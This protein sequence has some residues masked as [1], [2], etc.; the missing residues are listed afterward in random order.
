[1]TTGLMPVRMAVEM[2]CPGS[3]DTTMF[4]FPQKFAKSFSTNFSQMSNRAPR[5]GAASAPT[6]PIARP[7]SSPSQQADVTG[8]ITDALPK[9]AHDEGIAAVLE[10]RLAPSLHRSD[11][12]FWCPHRP[13]A[14]HYISLT[15]HVTWKLPSP[16]NAMTR[17]L[18]RTATA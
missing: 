9:E 13:I 1:M 8:K 5:M 14:L 6:C 3:Q 11:M 17:R 7:C 18:P 16:M 15:W 12:I 10:M 2:S 4:F